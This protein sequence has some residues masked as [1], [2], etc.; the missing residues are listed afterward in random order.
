MNFIIID[1]KSFFIINN[2]INYNKQIFKNQI[3]NFYN[4]Q[5]M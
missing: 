4:E 2:Y 1:L 5:I 3:Y